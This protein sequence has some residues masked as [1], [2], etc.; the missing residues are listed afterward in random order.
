MIKPDG[1]YGK[2]INHVYP[3]VDYAVGIEL[4]KTK[5]GTYKDDL[6]G[7]SYKAFDD[8]EFSNGVV[9]GQNKTRERW[10]KKIANL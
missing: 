6:I 10:A 3:D 5:T 7:N 8:K 4:T 1:T 9:F 2:I